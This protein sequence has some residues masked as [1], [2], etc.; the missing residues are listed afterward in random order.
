MFVC[1][2]ACAHT[3]TCVHVSVCAFKLL[4]RNTESVKKFRGQRTPAWAE[5][6][7]AVGCGNPSKQ[8]VNFS[9]QLVI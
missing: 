2:C 7:Y 4:N 1:V 9:R 6:G 3:R 8:A 5:K